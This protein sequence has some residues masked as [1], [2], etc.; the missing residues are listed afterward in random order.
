M[1]HHDFEGVPFRGYLELDIAA[2]YL[3]DLITRGELSLLLGAGVSMS[4]GL[5]SWKALVEGCE[6]DAGLD[7]PKKERSSQELMEAIDSVRRKL[8]RDGRDGEMFAVVRR[9]LYPEQYLGASTYPDEILEQRMLIA[10]GAM[11]MSSSRGSV[12]DVFT[13]NFDDLLEWYLHLHGFTTQVVSNFP[14]TLRGDRDVAIFHP[15]GFL[16]LVEEPFSRSDWLVLSHSELVD[17]LT[18]DGSKWPLLLE[19]RFLSKRILAIGTSMNDIDL[20]VLF[21][22]TRKEIGDRPLGFVLV[23]TMETDK[24]EALLEAGL[25]PLVVGSHEAIPE[26]LMRV[27]RLAAAKV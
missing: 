12:S 2:E 19:S 7:I 21:R 27:C 10:I 9:N 1:S 16:P 18:G 3:A 17:R 14:M 5:P 25:V 6:A 13:L 11:V 23:A 8:H 24:Q 4:S 20:Q 15:H 22:K 26:F